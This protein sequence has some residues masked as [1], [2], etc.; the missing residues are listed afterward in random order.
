MLL[1]ISFHVSVL[2][3]F[4]VIW[5]YGAIIILYALKRYIFDY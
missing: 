5:S 3:V 1:P 4:F 2:V